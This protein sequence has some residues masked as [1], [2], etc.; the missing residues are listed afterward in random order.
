MMDQETIHAMAQATAKVHIKKV[1]FD[2][3]SVPII[4]I[5]GLIWVDTGLKGDGGQL[6]TSFSQSFTNVDK[7]A[8]MLEL[9]QELMQ[10]HLE[11]KKS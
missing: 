1:T 8:R 9:L 3:S 11:G 10:D 5:Q 7:G 2:L 4:T 6:S